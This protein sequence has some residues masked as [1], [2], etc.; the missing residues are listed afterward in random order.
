MTSDAHLSLH[1]LHSKKETN[2]TSLLTSNILLIHRN[3]HRTVRYAALYRDSATQGPPDLS[4]IRINNSFL[5]VR[6][7]FLLIDP[8]G[9]EQDRWQHELVHWRIVGTLLCQCSAGTN[10][11]EEATV[12]TLVF[13]DFLFSL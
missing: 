9:V 11:L 6:Y 13:L 7:S 10:H 3:W 4:K 5:F 2:S 1:S 8:D 12:S